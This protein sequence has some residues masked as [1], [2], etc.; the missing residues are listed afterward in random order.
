MGFMGC[1][2]CH[3]VGEGLFGIGEEGGALCRHCAARIARM[4]LDAEGSLVAELWRLTG[5][6]TGGAAVTPPADEHEVATRVDLARAYWQMGLHPDA[7]AE[8]AIGLL[9]PCRTADGEAA[10][11]L[12][13]DATIARPE[14]L[15]I[16]A[17]RLRQS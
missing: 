2:V 4:V 8:A 3:A 1:I 17:E 5:P 7:V 15:T 14:A 16:L 9:G 6:V 10:L 12:L 13:F 11:E